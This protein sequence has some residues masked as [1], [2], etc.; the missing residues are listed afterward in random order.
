MKKFL[1]VFCAVVIALCCFGCTDKH[2]EKQPQHRAGRIV[3]YV[4]DS[5]GD[6]V[7]TTSSVLSDTEVHSI[8]KFNL[9]EKYL[10]NVKF[11]PGGRVD[12]LEK[13]YNAGEYGEIDI[14]YDESYLQ[15]SENVERGAG[16][17]DLDCLKAGT[18]VRFDIK[19]T[20]TKSLADG[21]SVGIYYNTEIILAD[22]AE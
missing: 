10:I 6:R 5:H 2:K 20:I 17:Y 1:C 14:D 9:G 13:E 22:I 16:W 15:I 19:V 18:V 4:Y 8:Y 7:K 12:R 21:T 3:T 11:L